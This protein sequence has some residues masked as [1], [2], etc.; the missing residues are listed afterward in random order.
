MA[1][2][3]LKTSARR[4]S[5]R[6]INYDSN[7]KASQL[8]QWPQDQSDHVILL[9]KGRSFGFCF[10]VFCRS[11]TQWMSDAHKAKTTYALAGRLVISVGLLN[12][13]KQKVQQDFSLKEPLQAAC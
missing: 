1:S 12:G 2:S 5:A 10:R 3:D 9:H 6:T 4:V 7:A 11:A 13:R 8:T